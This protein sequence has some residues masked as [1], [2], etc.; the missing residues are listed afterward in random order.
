M[1]KIIKLVLLL[2]CMAMIFHFSSETGSDSTNT[3][4]FV[5]QIVYKIYQSIFSGKLTIS[6][7][8]EYMMTP[9]RKI[10]HFSE[11][12]LLGL[13]AYLNAKEY[14]NKYIIYSFIFSVIY[15]ISDEIHQLF[16]INRYGCF[17]DV[18]IDSF[19]IM[20]GILFIYLIDK[21]C[22]KRNY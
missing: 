14:T 4:S 16:V 8:R 2:L 11:F 18:C 17:K 7:F 12:F 10:A 21:K 13:L 9:I 6:T 22:L 1:R 3:S 5:L 19:G 15:A 20:M